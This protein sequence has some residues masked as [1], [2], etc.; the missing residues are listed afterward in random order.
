MIDAWMER[1]CC[2]VAPGRPLKIDCMAVLLS[3]KK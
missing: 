3:T 2:C 1:E